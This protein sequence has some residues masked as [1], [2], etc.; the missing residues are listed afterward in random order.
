MH[1][2]N[3]YRPDFGDGTGR[4]TDEARET[5][6]AKMSN[7]NMQ[8]YQ[9]NHKYDYAKGVAQNTAISTGLSI[10]ESVGAEATLGHVVVPYGKMPIPVKI[11]TFENV[12][13]VFKIVGVLSLSDSVRDNLYSGKYA[14]SEGWIRIGIDVIA[15]GMGIALTAGGGWAAVGVGLGIGLAAETGKGI[16]DLWYKRQVTN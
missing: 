9:Q 13:R 8:R 12:G 3:G 4:E 5:S 11:S 10:G 1:D 6:F 14:K 16:V 2:Y 15:F 7:A